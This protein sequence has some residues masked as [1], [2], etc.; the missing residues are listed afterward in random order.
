[1]I[2]QESR[3]DNAQSFV[4]DAKVRRVPQKQLEFNKWWKVPRVSTLPRVVNAPHVPTKTTRSNAELAANQR[5]AVHQPGG[6][7]RVFGIF[8]HIKFT[9]H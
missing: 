3:G 8:S 7:A 4:N 1:M 6:R 5:F 9:S 2:G